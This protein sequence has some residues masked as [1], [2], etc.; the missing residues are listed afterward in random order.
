MTEAENRNVRGFDFTHPI[1]FRRR[2]RRSS[3]SRLPAC[4]HGRAIRGP[5]RGTS[6]STNRT[7]DLGCGQQQFPAAIRVHAFRHADHDRPRRCGLFISPFQINSVPGPGNPVNQLGRPSD[8]GFVSSDNG[9]T[10]Q[11][12]LTNPARAASSFNRM[13]RAWG[14]AESG[15]QHRLGDGGGHHPDRSHQPRNTGGS[16]SASNVNSGLTGSSSCPISD[17]KAR[18]S[19]SS[20]SSTTCRSSSA[21]RVR[22]VTTRPRRSSVRS[23]RIRSRD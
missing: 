9:L 15:S 8:T 19:P 18:T 6:M 21:R 17:R 11:A 16:A 4:P 14:C 10:F 1:R 22:F 3:A 2:P 7:D 5:R 13:A 23:S 12:N 20:N